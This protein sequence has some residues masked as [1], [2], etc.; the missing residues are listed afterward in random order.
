MSY[1]L[2]QFSIGIK[3]VAPGGIKSNYMNVMK[4]AEDKSYDPLMQRMTEGFSDGTLMEFSETKLIADVVYQAATDGKDQLRYLA[5]NDAVRIYTK[6]LEEG[7]EAY[8]KNLTT[9]LNLESPY[10]AATL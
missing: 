1:D 5:G 4:V 3:T 2:A 10:A 8:R 9:Y 6:R 7:T